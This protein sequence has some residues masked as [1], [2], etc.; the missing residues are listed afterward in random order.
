MDIEIK[1]DGGRERGKINKE[2]WRERRDKYVN[3]EIN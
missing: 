3:T 2:R 1:K